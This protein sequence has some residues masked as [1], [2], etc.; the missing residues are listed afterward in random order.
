MKQR[1]QPQKPP[2][3]QKKNSVGSPNSAYQS[4]SIV[5]SRIISDKHISVTPEVVSNQSQ[6][7]HNTQTLGIIRSLQHSNLDMSTQKAE[8]SEKETSIMMSLT[9]SNTRGLPKHEQAIKALYV[10][11]VTHSVPKK[12]SSFAA[13]DDYVMASVADSKPAL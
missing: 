2:F 8:P 11:Q 12:C 3:Q 9:D 7:Q 13:D 10:T 5:L 1:P 4:A 6:T